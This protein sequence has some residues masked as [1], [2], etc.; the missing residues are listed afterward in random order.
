MEIRSQ[1]YGGS[2]RIFRQLPSAVELCALFQNIVQ[3]RFPHIDIAKAETLNEDNV[4]QLCEAYE[5]DLSPAR[6]MWRG[7][8]TE[9][10]V[11][12][13]SIQ[14]DVLWDRIRL[15]VQRPTGKVDDVTDMKYSTG[16][17]S[18]TLQ[19]HRDTWANNVP[20]QLN[21]WAPLVPLTV[22]RTLAI[23]PAYFSTAIPNDSESWS[24]KQ[25]LKSRKS[26]KP[27]PQLPTALLDELSA[28]ERQKID[29]NMTPIVISPGDVLVFSGAHLHG[30]VVNT[31][32]AARYSTEVRTVDRGDVLAGLGAPNVDGKSRDYS[33]HW[34]KPMFDDHELKKHY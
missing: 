19:L 27:Y 31:S 29:E 8:V 16:R 10:S 1:L 12:A 5:E 2:I 9:A 24:I 14:S 4:M 6:G 3:T 17:F 7:I 33:V 15:R 30:S 18:G 34:F 32:G 23:Y 25:M 26:L 13:G 28:E 20:Q 11:H 22:D 21:W